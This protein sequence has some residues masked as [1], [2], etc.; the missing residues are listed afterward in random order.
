MSR[1]GSSGREGFDA[2]IS[3]S[4]D[5]DMVT[6]D[7]LRFWMVTVAEGPTQGRMTFIMMME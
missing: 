6:F 5:E 3:N 1:G 2:G 7:Q 4:A